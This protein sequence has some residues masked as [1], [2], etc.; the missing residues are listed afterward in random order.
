VGQGAGPSVREPD[1]LSVRFDKP[2]GPGRVGEL[3]R[4]P[5]QAVGLGEERLEVGARLEVAEGLAE[6]RRAD[7]GQ[8]RRIAG[9]GAPDHGF[10]HRAGAESGLG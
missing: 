1:R 4:G 2:G 9:A 3:A 6:G 5:L 8:G 7:G 10:N